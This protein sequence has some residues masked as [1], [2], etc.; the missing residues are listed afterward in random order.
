MP[1]Y[2]FK[3]IVPDDDGTAHV[4]VLV[5]MDDGGKAVLEKLCGLDISSADALNMAMDRYLASKLPV[6]PIVP[7]LPDDVAALIDQ[8]QNVDLETLQKMA[9]TDPPGPISP[10]I[11]QQADQAQQSVLELLR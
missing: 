7:V 11:L 9:Q 1:N 5:D 4:E 2:T 6:A 8:P 10:P 3:S